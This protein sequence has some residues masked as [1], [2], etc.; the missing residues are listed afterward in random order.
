MVWRLFFLLCF[1]SSFSC[2]LLMCTNTCFPHFPHLFFP[3]FNISYS[4][5]CPLCFHVSLLNRPGSER[6]QHR[7]HSAAGGGAVWPGGLLVSVCGLELRG[8]HQEPQSPC[9]HRLWVFSS[10]S[11]MPL[12]SL[13]LPSHLCI[14][15]Q[16]KSLSCQENASHRLPCI[17]RQIYRFWR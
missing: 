13:Y 3:L 14:P 16:T 1:S 8:D 9:P 5:P 4:H 12:L 17:S 6:G 10:Y 11:P 7:D 15:L 2:S